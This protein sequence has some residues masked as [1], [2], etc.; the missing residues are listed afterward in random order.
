MI[1]KLTNKIIYVSYCNSEIKKYISVIFVLYC[2]SEVTPK[3]DNIWYM[4]EY[5][6]IIV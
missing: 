2:D 4:I 6:I 3:N 1:V 5:T